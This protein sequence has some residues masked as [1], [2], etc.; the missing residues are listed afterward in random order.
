MSSFQADPGSYLHLRKLGALSGYSS[1]L[2][3]YLYADSNNKQAKYIGYLYNKHNSNLLSKSQSKQLLTYLWCMHFIRRIIESQLLHKYYGKQ[4][5]YE[6]IGVTLYYGT[7]SLWNKLHL[8]K[9]NINKNKAIIGSLIFLIGEFG[10]FYHHYLLKTFRDELKGNTHI[11]IEHISN[12]GKHTA[13]DLP[14]LL[15]PDCFGKQE[16]IFS[17]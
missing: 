13:A 6:L 4:K 11:N 2:I 10:N 9:L 3:V 12:S 1:A 17:N 8:D 15:V 14:P 16:P 7:F 5:F